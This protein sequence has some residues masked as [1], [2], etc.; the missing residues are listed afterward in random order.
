MPERKLENFFKFK[1]GANFNHRNT[2][3]I[4]RIALKLHCVPKFK[5]DA[6]IGKI[7]SFRSGTIYQTT[8]GYT[9]FIMKNIRNF[10]I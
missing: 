10:S 3:S 9:V 7:S 4:S 1:E 2:W 5:P 6:E 8:L